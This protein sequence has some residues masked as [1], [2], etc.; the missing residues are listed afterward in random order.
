MVVKELSISSHWIFSTN[1]SLFW[2][3]HFYLFLYG[4]LCLEGILSQ[5]SSVCWGSSWPE[6]TIPICRGC[7]SMIK[8]VC[9]L[10]CGTNTSLTSCGPAQIP[11]MRNS[12]ILGYLILLLHT[13]GSPSESWSAWNWPLSSQASCQEASS[14]G[15]TIRNQKVCG[16]VFLLVSPLLILC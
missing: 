16:L 2:H 15:W 6:P 11:L 5:P 3:F 4:F 12:L 14:K 7:I 8:P 9:P 10:S 13:R 1:A